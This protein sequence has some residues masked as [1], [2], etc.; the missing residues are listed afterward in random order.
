MAEAHTQ[1][2]LAAILAADV[3]GYSRMM[4]EDEDGT[5]SLLKAFKNDVLE[6]KTTDHNGRIFSTAG[7]GALIEF[8]SVVDA[9][10]CALDVQQALNTQ[11]ASTRE[12]QKIELRMGINLGDVIVEGNDLY[13]DGV[14]VAARLESLAD[15]GSVYV[16]GTVFE[17]VRNTIVANFEDLGEQTVKNIDRPV[18][19][20]RVS[21]S[22]A[23]ELS[24]PSNKQQTAE[25]DDT[26]RRRL[27]VAVLPVANLG[28]DQNDEPICDGIT[29]DII[30]ALS[31][32]DDLSV[33]SRTSAM[34]Y[35]DRS[36][37]VRTVGQELGAAYIL[38]G[39]IRRAGNRIRITGQLIDVATGHH[40]WAERYDRELPDI[41]EL[42]DDITANIA[43]A[44]QVT[45][46]EGKQAKSW[47]YATRNLDAWLAL[48][49]ARNHQ[50]QVTRQ[51]LSSAV[52]LLRDAVRLDP[53][54]AIACANLAFTLN[55]QARHSLVPD[56]EKALSEAEELI[57][58]A[59]TLDGALGI[60]YAYAA[61]LHVTLLRHEE[62]IAFAQRALEID[63][64]DGE[65]MCSLALAIMTAGRPEEALPIW[66][67]AQSLIPIFPP[68]PHTFM[69]DCY[70]QMGR[71][72][73]ALTTVRA[74]I[75]QHPENYFVHLLAALVSGQL[76]LSK[77]ARQEIQALLEIDPDYSIG[78]IPNLF[79][80]RDRAAVDDV[81]EVFRELGIGD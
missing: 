34:S 68:S 27:V 77:E 22:T 41:F 30:T 16:S 52:N 73:E 66:R 56:P 53:G 35:K 8:S 58:R 61:N 1:R 32:I 3:V 43:S 39:S 37:D 4:R 78:R 48:L 54:S 25:A 11:N 70:R 15:P 19:V 6:P 47:R 79:N 23:A 40:V 63:P 18:R 2:K 76:G 49:Q 28:G 69:A 75:K 62:A 57:K 65:G 51:G 81:V 21:L 45:F 31:K 14:N 10:Q 24:T 29:E 7:D 80:Y 26:I 55:L 46:V 64:N 38:E 67:R 36:L 20:V 50:R 33:V 12:E 44:L 74:A 71:L 5:L 59:I 42:Q 13:G 9:V 17:S 72:D 60:S